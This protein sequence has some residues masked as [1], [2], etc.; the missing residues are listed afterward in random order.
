MAEGILFDIQRFGLHDGPGIRTVVF[1]K[2]CPLRCA[3]CHNPESQAR[4]PQVRFRQEV[5]VRCGAC[6]AA[7]EHGAHHIDAHSHFYDRSL[8]VTC[9]R[10]IEECLYEGLAL[11]GKAYTVEEVMAV[12]RRDAVYFEQSGGGITLT[13]GEPLAQPT[14]A[15]SL[16]EAAHSE[17]IHT[18]LESSGVASRAVLADVLPWVDLFLYDYKATGDQHRALTGVDHCLILENLQ[19]LFEQ[20]AKVRL[21]CPL[22]P[23]INDSDEHLSAIADLERRYPALEG[24]DLLPYH[25]I[26]NDKYRQYGI[27][28]ALP[29]LPSASEEDR[30]RWLD[31]LRTLGCEKAGSG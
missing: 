7:C 26:G 21:R 20:G 24:I 1:F 25:N 22:A 18:C 17:G 4:A 29:D 13:G 2:G 27:A 31:R 9:G 30:R 14:F 15:R 3:W 10:C 8:C 5:C 12:V 23:G 19:F 6:A 11:T 28:N 16:L